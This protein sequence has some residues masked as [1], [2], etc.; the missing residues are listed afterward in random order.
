[1]IEI[2]SGRRQTRFIN[3]NPKRSEFFPPPI[4]RTA[5]AGME[6]KWFAKISRLIV[7]QTNLLAIWHSL[8][9]VIYEKKNQKE[10]K[11]KYLQTCS[12]SF[13][14]Q[15]SCK[16]IVRTWTCHLPPYTYTHLYRRSH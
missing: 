14:L 8:S 12:I 5:N 4:L 11:K 13:H 9:V 2:D 16:N 6:P 15:T 7:K 1:M 3:E 10:T